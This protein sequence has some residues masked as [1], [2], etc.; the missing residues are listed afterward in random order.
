MAIPDVCAIN[1]NVIVL[2]TLGNVT[3]NAG[4]KIAPVV[5]LIPTISNTIHADKARHNIKMN[6]CTAGILYTLPNL[7]I[8]FKNHL[9]R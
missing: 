9:P 4:T 6:P 1:I 2:T 3:I 5:L 8:Y 7:W